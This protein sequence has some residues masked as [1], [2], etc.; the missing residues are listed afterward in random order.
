VKNIEEHVSLFETHFHPSPEISAKDYYKDSLDAGVE[1]LLAVG[2]DADTCILAQNYAEQLDKVWF[3]AGVH[4]HEASQYINNISDFA[5][6]A[7]HEKFVA[8]GEIGLDYFYENSVREVQLEVFESFLKIALD[9]RK[10]AIIHCRD[11]DEEDDAYNDVYHSL[12]GFA[13][14]GGTFV[15]HCFTG[16]VEWA[17]KFLDIGAYLGITGIVTFPR[18]Q[19]VRDVLKMIPLDRLLIET[20]TPYLAPVPKRGK[21]NHSKYLPYIA[22]KIAEEK[23]LSLNEIAEITTVNAKKLLLIDS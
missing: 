14:S 22:E 6:F 7:K 20:D 11:K 15:I 8:V 12:K 19:N 5:N 21:T 23:G 10:P 2:S 4:P 13:G 3:T 17:E 9:S 18:A 1:Y 16:T